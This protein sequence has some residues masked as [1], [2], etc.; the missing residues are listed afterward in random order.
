M[1][2]LY[3]SP[4]KGP[5][6]KQ[7]IGG[8]GVLK[9]SLDV[10]A[11]ILGLAALAPLLLLV[12]LAVKLD[13]PGPAL[14]RQVRVGRGGRLFRINKFRTMTVGA[15][16]AG[17]PLTVGKDPR[18]TRLGAVLRRH[19]LDELPQLINVLLGDMS[20]VGP[21][22]EVPE[23]L[24]QYSAAAAAAVL[25][26]KPGL[27]DDASILLRDEST[28]LGGV[29]DPAAYYREVI[30]PSKHVYHE[31]YLA[32]ACLTE[33]LRVIAATLSLLVL[34]RIPRALDRPAPVTRLQG[35][36]CPGLLPP[37]GGAAPSG[38]R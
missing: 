30:V 7:G 24:T 11:A 19:K 5:A 32:N 21:R 23:L 26:V 29:A 27:T 17:A 36:E 31:R 12:A 2:S 4:A 6:L 10:V 16:Q 15:A 35:P 37:A 3:S 13:S 38:S 14:F 28:M 34:K 1:S 22:P 25:S 9:R 8:Y 18:I 33:D 20:L